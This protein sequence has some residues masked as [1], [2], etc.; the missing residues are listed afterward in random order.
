MNDLIGSRQRLLLD[1]MNDDEA[2]AFVMSLLTTAR[3]VSGCHNDLLADHDATDGRF[4]S[5]L[6]ISASPGITPAALAD[7]IGV[8]RATVTGLVD[9]LVKRNLVTRTADDQDRRTL[10]LS[11]TDA[12]RTAADDLVPAAG[13][14]L[15]ALADGIDPADRAAA[16]RVFARIAENIR[17][18]T[19]ET[20]T[21]D[22]PAAAP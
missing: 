19:A 6:A 2:A 15:S 20:R 10:C 3:R 5:L 7:T 16:L 12:G 21:D 18:V 4:A 22:A 1:R 8:S 14:R 13:G 17:A 11:V 9:G